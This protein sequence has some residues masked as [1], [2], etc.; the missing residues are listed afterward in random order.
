MTGPRYEVDPQRDASCPDCGALPPEPCIRL[1]GPY[2]I[3]QPL[4]RTHP[5][6][7]RRAVEQ[8]ARELTRITRETRRR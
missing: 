4:R 1:S 5:A 6:R 3:G 8:A 2:G 7:R